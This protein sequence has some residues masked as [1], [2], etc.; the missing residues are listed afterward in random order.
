MDRIKFSV[1]L[2]IKAKP[3]PK[4]TRNGSVYYADKDYA[5]WRS[6]VL[7]RA[8]AAAGKETFG[9]E[10]LRADIVIYDDSFT[11]ELSKLGHDVVFVRSD[12][13]NAMGSVFDALQG[14]K[15]EFGVIENDRYIRE[16]HCRVAGK[17]EKP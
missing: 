17:G 5:Y 3:R 14:K 9:K 6:L 8:I 7:A 11:V 10:P 4:V 1:P 13:D 15:G 2:R 16:V 12:I